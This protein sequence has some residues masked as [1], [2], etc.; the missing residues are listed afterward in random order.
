MKP[1][2]NYQIIVSLYLVVACTN[3]GSIKTMLFPIQNQKSH[4]KL[5]KNEKR[6]TEI[7]DSPETVY[8]K[9]RYAT[10]EMNIHGGTIISAIF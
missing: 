8:G 9:A 6:L 7:V 4:E 5:I 3:L 10:G 1:L 2:F